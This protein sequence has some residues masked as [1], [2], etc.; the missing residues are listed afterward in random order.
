MKKV[1]ATLLVVT[2]VGASAFA[3]PYINVRIA[4]T[5]P[6][7][8][9]P[10]VLFTCGIEVPLGIAYTKLEV[11]TTYEL[12]FSTIPLSSTWSAGFA[13]QY[14][15]DATHFKMGLDGDSSG[16]WSPYLEFKLSLPFPPFTEVKHAEIRGT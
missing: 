9:A 2:L 6:T 3:L 15:S 13:L 1:L 16:T 14:G 8:T 10:T 4:N 5:F 11:L 12:D 7:Q